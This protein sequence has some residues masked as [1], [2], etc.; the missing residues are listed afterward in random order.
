MLG[1]IDDVTKR[2]PTGFRSVEGDD[3]GDTVVLL[4]ASRAEL[5]GSEWA[6]V[7]HGHLGGLP[8]VV[9]LAAE[10]SLA[11]L[12]RAAGGSVRACS[13]SAHDLSD[14]GL[15]QALV[16]SALRHMCGVRVDARAATRSWR[17]SPSRRPA[18]SSPSPTTTSSALL[19]LAGTHEVPAAVLG[20]TGGDE[21]SSRV[22]S[23]STCSSCARPG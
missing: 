7:V 19:A 14:G 18:C 13:P 4:G 10:K 16:E 15:S 12:L 6:H 5:S 8:P 20:T 17:C 11:E 1:V 9:D 2:T 21:L 3:P 23:R 22:S